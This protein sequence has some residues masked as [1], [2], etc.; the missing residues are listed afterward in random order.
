MRVK[1][2]DYTIGARRPCFLIAEIGINHNG[3]VD[4]AL[5]MMK[6]AKETGVDAIKIQTFRTERFMHPQNIEFNSIRS[7]EL[8]Y[9]DQE[10]LFRF[11]KK[12]KIMLLS[13]PEDYESVDFLERM[14]VPA[15]KI[16]SMDMDYHPFIEYVAKKKRPIFLS[17]GMATLKEVKETLRII[18]KA[19]NRNIILLHC[20]SNYPA[21]SKDVNLKAIEKMK[22]IFGLPVGFS[23]HTIGNL[24]PLTA[25][26]LGA[27]V[28]EKH[29]TLNKDLPGDDH[30]LSADPDD[31]RQLV[32]GIRKVE[33]VI[34]NGIK[35]PCKS[36][37]KSI[38]LKKRGL[39]ANKDIRKSELITIDK[40]DFLCPSKG[41]LASD[42]SKVIGKKATVDIV[43]GRPVQWNQIS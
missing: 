34:G 42:V 9:A 25:V 10:K 23:D 28:I 33:A 29:F 3:R 20:V 12:N 35:K 2:K 18:H 16:A 15:Y 26:A 43:S 21:D 37:V 36:E 31:F 40:L 24:V 32:A 8:G 19:K 13:T 7:V 1:I 27:D 22:E 39:Y 4:W 17:T 14:D 41:I 5:E 30:I 38:R 6:R 11:A